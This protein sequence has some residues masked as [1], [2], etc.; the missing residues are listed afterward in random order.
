MKEAM[1]PLKSSGGSAAA[2]TASVQLE[3][4]FRISTGAG[5]YPSRI[6]KPLVSSERPTHGKEKPPARRGS[7]GK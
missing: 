7:A 6:V 3:S 4:L 1:K 2:N 5:E